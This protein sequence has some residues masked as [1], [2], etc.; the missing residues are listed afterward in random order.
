VTRVI[1]NPVSG[2]RIIVRRSGQDTDGALLSFDLFLPPGKHVPA[3]H[4]HPSQEEA[5]TVITGEMRFRVGRRHFVA[6][7]GD[8]VRVPPGTSHW[9]GNRSGHTV[10]AFVEAR[11]ALR[12]EELFIANE[13]MECRTI[14]GRRIPHF[15]ALAAALLDYQPEI[16]APWIPAWLARAVLAVPA[17]LGRRHPRHQRIA[18]APHS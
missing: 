18:C 9:F 5:F 8:T 12:L 4:A 13:A 3:S 17:R 7:P 10:H 11:P 1:E 15:T 6:R 16:R 2:E 14:A